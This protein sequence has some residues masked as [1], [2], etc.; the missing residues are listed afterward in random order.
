MCKF[1]MSE[2]EKVFRFRSVPFAVIF[3]G[4]DANRSTAKVAMN[5]RTHQWWNAPFVTGV[6]RSTIAT[7]AVLRIFD[8]NHTVNSVFS[9]T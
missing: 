4:K 1:L 2:I 9:R 6:L 5:Q 8:P 7:F 3:P